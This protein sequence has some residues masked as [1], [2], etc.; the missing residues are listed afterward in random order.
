MTCYLLGTAA[1]VY[2][3]ANGLWTG[4]IAWGL[5]PS[6]AWQQRSLWAFSAF[7]IML[8]LLGALGWYAFIVAP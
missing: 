6:A 3:L 1:V 7:G 8:L 2:H 4:A 5:T